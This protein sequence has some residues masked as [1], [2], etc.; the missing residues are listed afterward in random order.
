MKVDVVPSVYVKPTVLTT[1]CPFDPPLGVIT[2]DTEQ[3]TGIGV[4]HVLSKSPS[5][6]LPDGPVLPV[7]VMTPLYRPNL[8]LLKSTETPVRR[9]LAIPRGFTMT[10]P[11]LS[12][13]PSVTSVNAVCAQV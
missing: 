3:L 9:L 12:V 6:V 7:I 8:F 1:E 4:S 2:C 10:F 5:L 13:F 11:S